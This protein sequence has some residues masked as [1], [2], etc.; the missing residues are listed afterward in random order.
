VDVGRTNG[1]G[2]VV[3]VGNSF[4]G[5]L[6]A[7]VLAEHANGVTI[8]DRDRIGGD[9]EHRPGVPQGRHIHVLLAAGQYSLEEL[10]PGILAEFDERGVQAVGT[11]GDIVQLLR[12]RWVRRIGRP[13][14]FLT[15]TR[16]LLEHMV[17]QRVL[18]DPRIE[19]LDG[20]EAVGLIGDRGRV[21]G[22]MI[23][24]RGAPARPEP[25]Q[26]PADLVVDASGRGSHTPQWLTTIGAKLPAEERIDSGLCYTTR[27]YHA[28]VHPGY[29]GIY[30]FPNPESTRGAVVMP[31]EE[32]G[33]FLVTLS[34]LAG[35]EPP[36]DPRGFETFA[37]QLPH[38]IVY[39]WIMAA[40]PQGPP[41]GFRGTAN[42]RRRYERLGGRPRGLLVVGD[43]ACSFNPV[44]GQ[45]I[46]VAAIAALAL[47]KALASGTRST[48]RLQ[49]L[50][51]DAAAPAW[52][53]SGGADKKMPGATGNAV[54]P[55]P[56]DRF[57][58][59]YLARV[60]A[61]APGNRA[62]VFPFGDVLHLVAPARVL[63]SWP[64]MRAV[65]FGRIQPTPTEPPLHPEPAQ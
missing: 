44:Y 62:V 8:V 57:A 63:F 65:L 19:T 53:I 52:L 58:D 2:R 56:A 13:L 32:R 49:R 33:A 64:V 51:F 12:G 22:L 38:P 37:K 7:A 21:R 14:A 36:T 47:R 3:I 55:G 54:R 9:P 6:T 25:E 23:E 20:V 26:L 48:R 31:I 29:K 61:H 10:M 45:G 1:L 27:L 34:G 41:M 40:Q 43:A 39:D 28:P 5:L 35:D 15:G 46:A 11:P 17:R 4:A 16:P 24:R 59:W 60:E 18:A 42:V 30:L 50:V